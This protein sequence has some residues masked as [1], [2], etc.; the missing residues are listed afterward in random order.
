[1]VQPKKDGVSVQWLLLPWSS[2]TQ[3][4]GEHRQHE[5]ARRDPKKH[6]LLTS[7][8][9]GHRAV[10]MRVEIHEKRPGREKVYGH[11]TS[12]LTTRPM[13]DDVTADLDRRA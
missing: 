5:T 3:A 11:R 6:R 9:E 1:M 7:L 2:V 13:D 12:L 8:R 4:R 10:G